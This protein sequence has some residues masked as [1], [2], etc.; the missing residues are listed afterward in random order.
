MNI[1]KQ[2]D[3]LNA[4]RKALIES[5]TSLTQTCE[6]ESRTFT[7]EEQETF[8]KYTTEVKTV[9]GQIDRLKTML[10]LSK[11]TAEPPAALPNPADPASAALPSLAMRA[12]PKGQVFTRYV[13]ALAQAKGDLMQAAAIARRWKDSTPEVEVILKSAV[14]VGTTADT[15]WASELV[16]Y[17]VAVNEFIDLLRPETIIGRMTGFRAVPFN[18]RIQRET[19]GASAGWVGEGKPKPVSK[20]EFDS[21][22]VPHSKIAVIVALTEELVRF[23]TPSAESTTQQELVRAVAQFSDTQFIDPTVTV[24]AGVRPASI[25]NGAGHIGSAG[26]SLDQVTEDMTTAMGAMVTLNIPMRSRYWILNPRS[27]LYLMTLR[28]TAG[29]WAFREEMSQGKL[30]GIPFLTSNSVPIVSGDTMLI[31]LEASEILMADDGQVTID[32]SR[33]ASL[34][35][36]SA[37]QDGAQSLISLWQNN[38]VGVRAERYIHWLRR[39]LGAAYYITGVGY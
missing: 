20:L 29:T 31:L 13:M 34:Q 17:V 39:R 33:E 38:L 30:L 32:V 14:D 18:I 24:S 11:D 25:T 9:D 27:S 3:A 26:T 8:D 6:D 37:P 5:L 7:K 16:P 1:Q 10:V 12:R 19:V 23:S 22:V 15:E 21:I 4:K 36:D 2:L 35:M 28:T